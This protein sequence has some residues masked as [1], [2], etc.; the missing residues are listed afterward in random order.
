MLPPAVSS[1][2]RHHPASSSNTVPASHAPIAGTSSDVWY[3]KHVASI[4]LAEI[5]KTN[6]KKKAFRRAQHA[7][8]DSSISTVA[9]IEYVEE[10]L[11]DASDVPNAM[12]TGS[13]LLQQLFCYRGPQEQLYKVV[14]VRAHLPLIQAFIKGALPRKTECVLIEAFA[15]VASLYAKLP[16]A[17]AGWAGSFAQLTKFP[18]ALARH[19]RE[20]T[21]FAHDLMT[22][23]LREAQCLQPLLETNAQENGLMHLYDQVMLPSDT[24]ERCR[25]RMG[26]LSCLCAILLYKNALIDI[27]AL[28]PNRPN[29]DNLLQSVVRATH[30]EFLCAQVEADMHL[31]RCQPGED[32][33]LRTAKDNLLIC[34]V[35]WI[36]LAGNA[37]FES[38][39]SAASVGF[40][41]AIG[42]CW[43]LLTGIVTIMSVN[44]SFR[45]HPFDKIE[46]QLWNLQEIGEKSRPADG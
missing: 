1:S 22:T 30:H 4:F 31:V 45:R 14:I 24:V 15:G 9:F 2:A 39:N 37:V 19:I 32:P 26:A 44:D 28:Q 27:L 34:S 40:S 13:K 17:Q 11:T 35:E 21:L 29:T 8:H 41:F 33:L 38:E 18:A 16:C 6:T 36:V 46:K 23:L 25:I 12:E 42:H 3:Q 20:G 7:I 10:L 43:P 5:A